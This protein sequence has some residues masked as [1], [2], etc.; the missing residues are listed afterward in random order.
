MLLPYC[1]LP[2]V[3]WFAIGCENRQFPILQNAPFVKQNG[4]NRYA[5][6]SPNGTQELT[7]PVNHA[8]RSLP[9]PL[10]RI[11]YDQD[12]RRTHKQAWQ[13]AYGKSPFYE[14]YD[15][16][17]WDVFQRKPETM[18]EIIEGLNAVLFQNLKI[19]FLSNYTNIASAEQTLI[20][21]QYL[22][23]YN[24]KIQ[25]TKILPYSQTFDAKFGFRQ[26]VSAIDL[27]FNVGPLSS[28]YLQQYAQH[29]I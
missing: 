28:D 19:P 21:E 20:A 17:F 2:T 23:A 16:R 12:W 29:S 13:T 1:L 10:V 8:D 3:S 11:S 24:K 14:Y 22:G 9:L 25:Q 15:Y 5:I 7:I 26:P 27:L 4:N 6:A 18:Q